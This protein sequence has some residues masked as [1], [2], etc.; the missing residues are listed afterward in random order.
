MGFNTSFAI[1][2]SLLPEIRKSP[3]F[4]RL[5]YES[6]MT[7]YRARNAPNQLRLVSENWGEGL[8]VLNQHHAD[9]TSLNELPAVQGDRWIGFVVLNDG[10]DQIGKD[11]KFAARFADMAGTVLSSKPIRYACV[12]AG[13]HGNPCEILGASEIGEPLAFTMSGNTGEILKS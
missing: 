1:K 4:G 7:F 6:A 13:N 12:G 5:L 10:I 8:V 2:A 3:D 11:E 9:G